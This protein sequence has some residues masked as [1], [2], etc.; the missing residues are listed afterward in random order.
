MYSVRI[1]S[2]FYVYIVN[3]RNYNQ[4]YVFMNLGENVHTDFVPLC[5]KTDDEPL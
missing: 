1:V 4:E 5:R 2:I 3:K